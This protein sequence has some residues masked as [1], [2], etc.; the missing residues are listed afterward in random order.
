M[1]TEP[2]EPAA[3]LRWES[4]VAAM[5]DDLGV[6][7]LISTETHGWCVYGPNK[8]LAKGS[9]TSVPRAKKAAA[10][11]CHAALDWDPWF[12]SK[13]EIRGQIWGL[14]VQ[15]DRAGWRWDAGRDLTLVAEAHGF[16]GS[17][18]AA[19]Q[20]AAAFVAKERAHRVAMDFGGLLNETV[21]APRCPDSPMASTTEGQNAG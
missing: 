9:S 17:A 12:K 15:K 14:E 20:A 11:A 4:M 7:I 5:I 16:A 6:Q 13:T 1:L 21:A 2:Q 3:D 19:Q 8:L 18:E 10:G